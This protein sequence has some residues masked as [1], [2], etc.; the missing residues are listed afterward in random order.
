MPDSAPVCR[1]CRNR[2]VSLDGG[3]WHAPTAPL[4]EWSVAAAQLDVDH[5]V[6]PEPV[7]RDA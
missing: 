2:V 4:P 3:W 6:D 5:D 1:I 7:G